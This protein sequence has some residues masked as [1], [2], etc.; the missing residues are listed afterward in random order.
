M[1]PTKGS[2]RSAADTRDG[3]S[4]N[5]AERG[6]QAHRELGQSPPGRRFTASQ[7]ACALV[8]AVGKS[9]LECAHK[10]VSMPL[11]RQTLSKTSTLACVRF[12]CFLRSLFLILIGRFA[13]LDP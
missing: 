12:V 7:T 1:S 9:V 5:Y 4:L 11:R 13:T 2:A 8:S 3:F 6:L 10:D